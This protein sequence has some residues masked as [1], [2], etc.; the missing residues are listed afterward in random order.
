MVLYNLELNE[1][2]IKLR[3]INQFIVSSIVI[4]LL[5]DRI[6]INSVI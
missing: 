3:A 4:V 2:H 1:C 5:V 6:F